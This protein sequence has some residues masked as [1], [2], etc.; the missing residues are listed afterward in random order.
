MHKIT[1]PMNV[2]EFNQNASKVLNS[3][4]EEV[5][6]VPIRR[7]RGGEVIAY[8]VPAEMMFDHAS[9]DRARSD[10]DQAPPLEELLARRRAY[11]GRLA[12]SLEE[13]REQEAR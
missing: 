13:M 1:P 8:V 5:D 3:V 6:I 4:R 9:I 12:R 10:A 2:R 7:G 11:D